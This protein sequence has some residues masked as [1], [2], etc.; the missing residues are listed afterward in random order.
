[1]H[2]IQRN[3]LADEPLEQHAEVAQCFAEIEHLRTQGLLARE[4]QQLP[5]KR[6]RAIGVLLD[7]HDVLKG[8]IGRLVRVQQ[9]V[10]RH[11]D[12]GEDI[13]EI[14]GDAARQ[15][16]DGLHFLLLLDAVFKRAL[17][18]G[19]QCV[20][21]RGLAVAI[22]FFDRNDEEVGPAVGT[23]GQ[24][25]LNRRDIALSLRGLPDCGFE[26]RPIALDDN[27]KDRAVIVLEQALEVRW[28]SAHCCARCGRFCR[29]SQSPSVCSGRNA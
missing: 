9:E 26:H 19:L 11:H 23:S 4:R 12:G 18:G 28:R 2:D 10:G 25:R 13:V 21:D 27:R 14:V 1:M 22:L 24:R 3:F 29:Q 6:G 8:R 7:L 15:L 16:A 17:R 20:D 5:H